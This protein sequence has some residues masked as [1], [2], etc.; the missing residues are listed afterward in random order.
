MLK[1][2]KKKIIVGEVRVKDIDVLL[3]EGTDLF[4]AQ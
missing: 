2:S 4:T 1:Q 3:S